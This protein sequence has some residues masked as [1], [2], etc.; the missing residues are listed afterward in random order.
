MMEKINPWLKM[1]KLSQRRIISNTPHEIFWIVDH[2]G[3]YGV[4]ILTNKKI[5]IERKKIKLK[6]IQITQKDSLEK[7]SDLFLIVQS[8]EDWEIFLAL[9][10][11]LTGVCLNYIDSEEMLQAVELRLKR[12]QKLLE[13]RKNLPFPIERQMGLLS[14]LLCLRD[15]ISKKIGIEQAIMSWNGSD[16]DKQDF[17]LDDSVIEVK[18]YR[19]SKGDIVHISSSN[20]LYSEKD[21]IY[22]VSYALTIS[23]NGKSIENIAD[24]IRELLIDSSNQFL[25]SFENKLL[26]YG[27]APE[28]LND[29]LY[30]FIVDKQRAFHVN[31]TFPKIIPSDI[32]KNILTV[33]YS[34]DLSKCRQFEVTL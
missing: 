13:E 14:E 4:R 11:D 7:S 3:N 16:Y 25:N 23:E 21:S 27:Y 29:S 26:N 28:V 18:S 31:E 8:N 17:L 12:W 5:K 20:Q 34:I 15:I 33:N 30:K 22:L 2:Y 6:G 10:N 9:C 24:N 1:E 32:D 19:T